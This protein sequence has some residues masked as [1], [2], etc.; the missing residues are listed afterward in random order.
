MLGV[1]YEKVM[2]AAFIPLAFTLGTDFQPAERIDRAEVL[3][4]DTW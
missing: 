2:L 3:H 1:P 4:W